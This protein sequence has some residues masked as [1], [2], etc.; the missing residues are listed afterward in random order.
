MG[1]VALSRVFPAHSVAAA[2]NAVP[3]LFSKLDGVSVDHGFPVYFG[4]GVKLDY[5]SNFESMRK[6]FVRRRPEGFY[7]T[8]R[9]AAGY[10]TMH[11]RQDKAKWFVHAEV[12]GP[13][14]S[15][16]RG[17]LAVIEDA[18]SRTLPTSQTSVPV[19]AAAREFAPGPHVPAS[20]MEHHE[21]QHPIRDNAI[22][23][24]I[25]AGVVA[26]VTLVLKLALPQPWF[27][28]VL[29][30]ITLLLIGCLLAYIFGRRL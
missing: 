5:G 2:L 19:V 12:R 4:D 14:E 18:V 17:A 27:W 23:G 21:A 6:E 10:V 22:G 28:P 25:A 26:L 9:V 1:E 7:L 13:A 8:F 20:G 15:A 30:G 24:I 11:M 3:E 16:V 29:S